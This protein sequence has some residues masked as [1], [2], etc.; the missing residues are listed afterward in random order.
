MAAHTEDGIVVWIPK[1]KVVISPE[2]VHSVDERMIFSDTSRL[3]IF[4]KETNEM[5]EDLYYRQLFVH[6]REDEVEWTIIIK[7]AFR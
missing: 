1:D 2:I 4:D 3:Q 6:L 7:E 5:I